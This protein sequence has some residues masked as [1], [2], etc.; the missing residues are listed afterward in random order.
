MIKPLV[1][2]KVKFEGSRSI[3]RGKKKTP[4]KFGG[5]GEVDMVST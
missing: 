1:G 2:L 4:Q 5:C 3:Y